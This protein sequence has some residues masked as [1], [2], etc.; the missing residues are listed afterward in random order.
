MSQNIVMKILI[1]SENTIGGEGNLLIELGLTP[2]LQGHG[3]Q[4]IL[5]E[6]LLIMP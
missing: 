2:K 3:E 6:T 5:E 4:K 1:E